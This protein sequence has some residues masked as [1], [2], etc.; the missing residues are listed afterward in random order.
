[1]RTQAARQRRRPIAV[2]FEVPHTDLNGLLRFRVDDEGG[3]VLWQI[4]LSSE[5]G[6]RIT[7]GLVPTSGKQLVP[8]NGTA[9]P[10]IRGRR[11][12]VRV[13]YQYDEFTAPSAAEFKKT[14]QVP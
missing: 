9:P 3:A 7:Y 1:M 14:I 8:A 10:D 11:V 4:D 5:Q 13:K 6:R 12:Q 2:V